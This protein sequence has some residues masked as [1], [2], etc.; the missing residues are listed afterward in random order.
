[1]Y[2]HK[3]VM[4]CVLVD[5]CIPSDVV[6]PVRTEHECSEYPTAMHGYP[7]A[8]ESGF[9]TDVHEMPIQSRDRSR[10]FRSQLISTARS[11]GETGPPAP[12]VKPENPGHMT[13]PKTKTKE[14]KEV[15]CH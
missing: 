2:T 1:M 14:Y 3:Q 7:S 12:G 15:S 5:D 4:T 11:A 8:L 9:R 13:W 10:L 6:P